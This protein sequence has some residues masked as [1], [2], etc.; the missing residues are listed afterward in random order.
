VK[1]PKKSGPIVSGD[2][3]APITQR[4]GCIQNMR[5]RAGFDFAR[6]CS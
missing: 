2:C 5:A 1:L 4:A 3:D 6:N